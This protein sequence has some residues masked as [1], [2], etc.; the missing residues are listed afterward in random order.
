MHIVALI[1]CMWEYFFLCDVH[2]PFAGLPSRP[3]E[4][5]FPQRLVWSSC[6]A[7]AQGPVPASARPTLGRGPTS[8]L[9]AG[10]PRALTL[11]IH[12][13][14]LARWAFWKAED[15]TA[16]T[17]SRARDTAR[18]LVQGIVERGGFG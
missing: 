6:R 17:R 5:L 7:R 18:V 16:L 12:R 10:T 9:Y 4:W 13:V 2:S 1:S 15:V 14:C 3:L 11:R 8:S